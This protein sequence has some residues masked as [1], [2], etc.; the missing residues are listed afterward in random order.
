MRD[1]TWRRQCKIILQLLVGST[2]IIHHTVMISHRRTAM[3]NHIVTL[4]WECLHLPPYG[5]DLSSRDFHL[6][7][8]LTK[9]LA[10]SNAEVKQAVK[11]FFRTQDPEVFFWRA[12]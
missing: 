10:G 7:P 1:H 6:F 9:N 12:F 11:C 4:S 8:A 3:Q 5:H 2:Y